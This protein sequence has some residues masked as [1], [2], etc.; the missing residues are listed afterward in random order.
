MLELQKAIR[1][2]HVLK[3][4]IQEY[5]ISEQETLLQVRVTSEQNDQLQQ[6]LI[7]VETEKLQI[8]QEMLELVEQRKQMK[9]ENLLL[10]ENISYQSQLNINLQQRL[11]EAHGYDQ[12]DALIDQ[13]Q[14][15]QQALGDEKERGAELEKHNTYLVNRDLEIQTS[16]QRLK[17]KYK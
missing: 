2:I 13:V 4:Q 8:E 11:D 10:K 7:Q 6:E 17:S 16:V 1:Q 15:L 5:Q 14:F 9:Q 3:T 12:S